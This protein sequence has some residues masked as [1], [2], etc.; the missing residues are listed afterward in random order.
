[1]LSTE[2][3]INKAAPPDAAIKTAANEQ[4]ASVSRPKILIAEDDPDQSEMLSDV[5]KDSGYEVDCALRGDDAFRKLSERRYDLIILDIRMP[6]LNGGTVL[7]A[8]RLKNSLPR[9]PVIVVSA[10]ASG[11]DK[12][13]YKKDGA[14]MSFSKPYE[15]NELLQGISALLDPSAVSRPDT[16]SG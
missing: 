1:M 11:A 6:G 4:R 8:F 15:L 12:A 5:L 13:R 9:T 16:Q 10:F 3:P 14:D 2:T 7:K